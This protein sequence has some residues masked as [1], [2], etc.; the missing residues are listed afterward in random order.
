MWNSEGL[1]KIE[2]PD[3][4]SNSRRFRVNWWSGGDICWI[5]APTMPSGKIHFSYFNIIHFC[6][7]SFSFL[8]FGHL[9]LLNIML[10]KLAFLNFM[11][12]SFT[13]LSNEKIAFDAGYRVK[14]FLLIVS[15]FSVLAQMVLGRISPNC[16]LAANY[17]IRDLDRSSRICTIFW[18]RLCTFGKKSCGFS[19]CVM[20]S[21]VARHSL[22]NLW[23]K[24]T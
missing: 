1:N 5:N 11:L 23:A 22:L 14:L 13:F 16:T 18:R 2:F 20:K 8:P 3:K 6:I 17:S 12:S 19:I 24:Y 21:I 7:S 9:P 15:Q 4:I 10:L